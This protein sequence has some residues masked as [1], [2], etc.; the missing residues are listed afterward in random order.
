MVSQSELKASVLIIYFNDQDSNFT[1]EEWEEFRN[2]SLQDDT[3]RGYPTK[4]NLFKKGLLYRLIK[5]RRFI[6]HNTLDFYKLNNLY[7]E[8]GDLCLCFEK[9]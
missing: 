5:K 9:G 8:K 2:S 3:K 6:F 1:G 4:L 7:V